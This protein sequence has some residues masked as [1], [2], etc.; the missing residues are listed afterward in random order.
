MKPQLHDFPEYKGIPMM[1]M[2]GNHNGNLPVYVRKYHADGMTAELH[3]HRFIQINYILS[4]RVRHVINHSAFE[5]V[6]GDVFVIPPYIPHRL[7]RA[8]DSDFEVFELEFEPDFVWGSTNVMEN[9][10]TFFDF[11]YIE[12]FL[13]CEG[14]VKPGLNI[15]GKD[16]VL[17]EGLLEEIRAEYAGR[18]DGYLLAIKADLLKLLVYLGRRFKTD[19]KNSENSAV[20]ES[21]RAAVDRAMTFI[22]THFTEDL[23]VEEVARTAM[24]SRS[25][26]CY[27]FKMITG[28]TFIGYLNELRVNKAGEMLKDTD[29]PVTEICFD[30]GFHSIS[31]F[32]RVFKNV[33]G[34]SPRQYRLAGSRGRK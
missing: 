24:L 11:A 15:S 7:E 34:I 20:F 14:E 31:H 33:T 29:A 9:I 30:A 4:G 22:S 21:H 8:G 32:N 23:T 3:R 19:M 2:D 17:V 1:T 18:T 25:Y 6:K 27:L 13:V 10:G 26:F 28:K 12:P 16:Q 5:V